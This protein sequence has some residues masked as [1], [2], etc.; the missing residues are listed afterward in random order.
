[1]GNQVTL[2]FAG[3]TKNVESSFD[4][5]GGSARQMSD[6]VGSSSGGFDR[7][8]EAADGAEGKAQG[9][10][11]TLTGTADIGAGTAAIMKGNLFEGF[12]LAGQGAADLAGGL[13]SFVIP[14]LAKTRVGTL[15]KAAADHVAAGAARVWAGAQWLMNTALLASPITWIVI[16]IV[17]L[18]A[19]IVL[20]AKRTDWFSK[21]WGAAWGWIKRAAS[22]TWEWLKRLPGWIGTAFSKVAGFITAPFRAAFNAIARLWNSTVGG[23]SFTVPAWIP[24]IGGRGFSVPNIPTLHAGGV[25]PGVVGDAVPI[26]AQAGERVG[27]VASSSSGDTWIRVDLGDLGDALLAAI[28]K[29]VGRRGGQVTHLGVRVINGTVRA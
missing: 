7:V 16:G 23:L 22:N 20:I 19:V 6:K 11:D 29:A 9:F 21:A 3:D 26:L 27:G 24:G 18:V 1:M 15:A 10:S 12:V 8:G 5:V 13:A 2:T 17:A 28:A 14:A 4:R 25:V